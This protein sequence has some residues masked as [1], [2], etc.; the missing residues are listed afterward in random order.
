VKLGGTAHH[1]WGNAPQGDE[2]SA[3]CFDALPMAM[4]R[5]QGWLDRVLSPFGSVCQLPIEEGFL[6]ERAHAASVRSCT[7]HESRFDGIGT[8]VTVKG[9]M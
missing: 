5:L 3:K 6:G 7:H 2:Q 8:V 4:K 1:G 9:L